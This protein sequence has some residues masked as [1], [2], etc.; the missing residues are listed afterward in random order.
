M[1]AYLAD[2]YFVLFAYG[3]WAVY[4]PLFFSVSWASFSRT[5]WPFSPLFSTLMAIVNVSRS[6]SI[7]YKIRLSWY[8]LIAVVNLYEK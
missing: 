3:D 2:L 5:D 7:T 6:L 4:A 8:A 1:W